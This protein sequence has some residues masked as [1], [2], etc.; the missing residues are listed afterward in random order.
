MLILQSL[1]NQDFDRKTVYSWESKKGTNA[2][3]NHCS[4]VGKGEH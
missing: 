4:N 1:L 2:E 3:G